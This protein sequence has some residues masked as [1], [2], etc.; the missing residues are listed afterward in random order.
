MI[1]SNGALV[2]AG[3]A[4]EAFARVNNSFHLPT[5]G[6]LQ[7]A[8]SSQVVVNRFPGRQARCSEG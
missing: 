3:G 5:P 6:Q 4:P 2:P 8:L 1:A 7:A